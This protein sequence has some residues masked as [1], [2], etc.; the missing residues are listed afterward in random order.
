MTTF[1]HSILPLL[2]LLLGPFAGALLW[3]MFW[4]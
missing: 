4:G 1:L 2:L 3:T